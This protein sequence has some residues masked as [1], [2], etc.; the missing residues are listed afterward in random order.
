MFEKQ[1]NYL[2]EKW[3]WVKER[4]K[5]IVTGIVAL[6][7]AG[8]LG[9][10]LVN[11][12]IPEDLQLKCPK[13]KVLFS[14]EIDW[15]ELDKN[16]EKFVNKG[17]IINYLC[18]SEKEIPQA[19]GEDISKRTK[20]SQI[21]PKGKNKEGKEVFVGRF[22]TGEP[23]YK[24]GDKWYQTEVATT[25]PDAFNRQ[26]GFNSL[27]GRTALAVAT[28][29]YTGA[30]DGRTNR[31]DS[32]WSSVRETNDSTSA[33]A[34]ETN[35][36]VYASKTNGAS[37][38][39][40]R[41]FLPV[42]TSGIPAAMTILTATLKVYGTAGGNAD[43]SRSFVV[44]ETTQADHTTLATT[45]FNEC[46]TLDNPDEGS[47]RMTLDNWTESDYNDFAL[48]ATGLGWVKKS[49]EASTCGSALTG[50]TC[51]GLRE[52]SKD[53][54]DVAATDHLYDGVHM[55]EATG[56]AT[57]PYLEITYEEEVAARR[58]IKIRSE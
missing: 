36:W 57:D 10:R 29:S 38:T 27:L 45:D 46:G 41:G 50:W 21:F 54:D 39:L 33:P 4:W 14:K 13:N 47:S 26:M 8:Y 12:P 55:S 23:F 52:A 5:K 6:A 44:V 42:D 19:D 56:T 53:I 58:T 51:L 43:A 3:N 34:T 28:S 31:D 35:S 49:E 15:I 32:T 37:Y 40:T 1:I 11:P 24:E 48:N 9:A 16:T 7:T 20:N 17:K 25:T 18:A 22:Y 2:I 30:G